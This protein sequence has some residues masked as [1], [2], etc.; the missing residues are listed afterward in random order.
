MFIS[1]YFQPSVM[2]I[3]IIIILLSVY[4]MYHKKSTS[5]KL[6]SSIDDNTNSHKLNIIT[7]QCVMGG[8]ISDKNILFINVLS[9]KI[10]VF[11]GHINPD[12]KK[13][14][15]KDEFENLLKNNEQQIPESIEMVVLMCAG[16]SCIAG[17][18]YYDELVKRNINVEKVVDYAGGLHEWALYS[19][20]NN[21]LFKVY[22]V[23]NNEELG[24]KELDELI[25]NTNHSY[26]TNM[27]IKDNN[28]PISE[29]CTTGNELPYKLM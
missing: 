27:L 20:L 10:P 17:E 29:L 28:S 23:A 25:E 4:T 7:P 16:W 24:D 3:G 11:I 22:N 9:E 13:C 21:N 15:T 5:N 1:N 18:L 8:L 12:R 6:S 14:I 19:K 26:K 2:F